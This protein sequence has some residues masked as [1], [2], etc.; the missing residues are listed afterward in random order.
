MGFCVA[1][2]WNGSS[3]LKVFPCTVTRCSCIASSSA[4]CV[5][6]GVR[7]ISSASTMLLKIGPG[8]NTIWRRPVAVSSWMMSVPVMSDGIRSGV[9]WMRVN[10]RSSTLASVATSSVLARPGTPTIRLL[11]PTKSVSSTSSMTSDC[12]MIRLPSSSMICW[13]PTFI[14]S[15][16]AM[17]SADSKSTVSTATISPWDQAIATDQ[18]LTTLVRH[19]VNDVVDADFVRFIGLVDRFEAGIGPLPVLRDVGVVVDHHHDP[20]RRI[21]VLIDRPEDRGRRIVI[22]RDVERLDLEE[23]VED[24]VR[25]VE[26]VNLRLRQRAQHLRLEV[27][28][29]AVPEVVD[30]EEAA[31]EQEGAQVR[32]FLRRHRPRPGFAEVRDG[33]PEQLRT[34]ERQDI[35]L[36][37]VRVEIAHLVEDLHEMLFARRVIVRPHHGLRGVAVV[38]TVPNAHEREAAVVGRVR[39]NRNRR[40]APTETAEA[41]APLRQCRA[42]AHRSCNQEREQQ[43]GRPLHGLPSFFACR[44]RSALV[45]S[46]RRVSSF[47]ICA[48]YCAGS[49]DVLRSCSPSISF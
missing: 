18:R 10:F 5:L 32:R 45:F 22:L 48:S 13:R 39:L 14:L 27:A 25:D 28:P 20:L 29:V 35:G 42:A 21:V 41:A 4:D 23:A 8:A 43:R 6:G 16:S 40:A 49:I 1:K 44:S 46:A 38:R 2:T 30:D 36:L 15:A 12:P 26:I 34:V 19:P 31:F 9:N 37:G 17:S 3:S 33:I 24:V 47:S 7:L 11:P